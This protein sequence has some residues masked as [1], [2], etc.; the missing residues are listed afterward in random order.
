MKP[1]YS[2]S[3]ALILASC[4]AI[5]V[6]DATK[7]PPPKPPTDT[8][9]PIQ[10]FTG[11]I[12]FIDPTCPQKPQQFCK[13]KNIHTFTEPDGALAWETD[14]WNSANAKGIQSGTTNGADIP[15]AA[16]IFV[17]KPFDP[18]II[19]AAI[20]HDHYTFAENRVRNWA[21]THRMYLEILLDQ[22][23]NPI[24]A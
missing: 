3:C 24:V 4:S 9:A 14:A 2:L 13:L 6:P 5:V 1:I 22:G 12:E 21:A 20:I 16:Q 23:V 15:K 19:Q 8:K 7:Q 17:G 10:N 18:G 11:K